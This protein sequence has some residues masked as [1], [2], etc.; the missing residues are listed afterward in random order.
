MIRKGDR[1][2]F[3][4]DERNGLTRREWLTALGGTGAGLLLPGCAGGTA[5]DRLTAA[6]RRLISGKATHLPIVQW[7]RQSPDPGS[8]LKS[9]ARPAGKLPRGFLEKTERLMRETLKKSGG[10]GLAA[11]QVGL[12]RRIVLVQ[13]QNERKE[14]VFCVDP[15]IVRASREMVDGYEACLSVPGVGGE[16][17][18]HRWIE[19]ACLDSEGRTRARR[20]EGWEARIFQHELDH[21]NGVLYLERLKGKLLPIDEVR[22]LRKLRKDKKRQGRSGPEAPVS[23]LVRRYRWV[24]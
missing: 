16:V 5:A 11:P 8:V 24:L 17:S 13:L 1:G 12:S 10:V 18:R 22:R 19:V 2:R 6:E 21:L 20:S 15:R 23:G 14:V 9:K 7:N 3:F 4:L